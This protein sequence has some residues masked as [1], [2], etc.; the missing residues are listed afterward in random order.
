ML[1]TGSAARGSFEFDSIDAEYADGVDGAIQ[2]AFH[3]GVTKP[4]AIIRIVT[5]P[6]RFEEVA[7]AP[8]LPGHWFAL[9]IDKTGSA[10]S[11][12][13]WH[14][15]LQPNGFPAHSRGVTTNITYLGTDRDGGPAGPVPR[16][17]GAAVTKQATV[18]IV[19]IAACALPSSPNAAQT[20]ASVLGSVTGATTLRVRDVGQASFSSL[21]D[22]DGKAVLHYDVGFP[23]SFNGHTSPNNF[24]LDE[25]E[26]P[27][28]VL[29]HWDWDH[30]HA[31]F[32]HPHLMDCVWLVPDQKLGPGAARLA[33]ILAA[34][35]R[36]LIHPAGT[37]TAFPNGEVAH[38]SGP[39]ASLNDAGLTVRVALASGR[40]VLLTGDVDYSF[41]AH[42][43][44]GSLNYLVA[45]HH[46]ARFASG[47]AA[48]PAPV[49]ESGTLL[50]SYG[51]RNVYRHP[52]PD[53]IKLHTRTG[54]VYQISTARN[55]TQLRGDR[56]VN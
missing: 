43:S 2:R 15:Q 27:P 26:K 7:G 18:P 13:T 17:V 46:G 52:H 12:P 56:E 45:T 44:I 8:G 22:K 30:L 47:P 9:E 49:R 55:G 28:I 38:A 25:T 31:A 54:W 24:D 48:I 41:L 14:A 39:R 36:L 37:L 34:K 23:I 16:S 3:E 6:H 40:S 50:L 10:T 11:I 19:V 42:P 35:G 21:C 51:K 33:R 1:S 29:S 20:I 4:F 53:A 32:L 5:T